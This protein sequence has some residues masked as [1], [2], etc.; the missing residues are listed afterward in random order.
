M[1]ITACNARA[2]NKDSETCVWG[3]CYQKRHVSAITESLAAFRPNE[4]AA[5][6]ECVRQEERDD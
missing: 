1:R 2:A 5:Q 6:M 4:A 3:D